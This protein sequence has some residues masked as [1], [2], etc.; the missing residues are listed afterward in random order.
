MRNGPHSKTSPSVGDWT[1]GCSAMF[2]SEELLQFLDVDILELH[3]AG[4][5]VPAL[6]LVVP[7]AVVLQGQRPFGRDARKL[8]VAD[9]FFAVELHGQA[10]ALH[11]DLEAVPF[12]ARPVH[13]LL[14][15]DAGPDLRRLLLVHAV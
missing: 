3:Q 1:T 10:V 4:R 15:R 2:F 11:G 6:G 8:G 13:A 7:A 9:D 5:A 14:R 12:T